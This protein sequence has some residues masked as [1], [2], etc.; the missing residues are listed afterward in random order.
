MIN[1]PTKLEV[2]SF[3]RYL[4]RYEV[5]EKFTKWGDL[6]WSVVTQA[7]RRMAMSPLHRAH[8]TSYSSLIETMRLSCTLFEIQRVICRS[9]P[10]LP[11]PTFIWR[12][13][14]G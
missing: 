9:S 7:H 10:T 6:E 3:T 13:R 1:I 12:P 4:L 2:R 11:Y 8:T 5:V 14:W